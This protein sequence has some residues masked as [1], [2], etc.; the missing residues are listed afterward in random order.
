MSHPGDQKATDI[1]VELQGIVQEREKFRIAQ[2]RKYLPRRGSA[3]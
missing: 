2:T 3:C 1:E